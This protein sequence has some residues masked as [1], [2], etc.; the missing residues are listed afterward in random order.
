MKLGLRDDQRDGL[1]LVAALVAVMWIE[2]V[3]DKVGKLDLDR[4]GIEPRDADGLPGIV[5]SP[6]LHAGFD[7]LISNTV[8]FLMLGGLIALAGAVRVVAVT[9]IVGLIAGFGT[10]LIAPSG[11]VTIGASGI[12]FGYAS[13][14]VARAVISRRA[15]E[16]VVAVVVVG[17]W[18]TTLLAGIFVPGSGIS[19]QDH[20]FGAIGGV[21]AASMLS[22]GDRRQAA[23]ASGSSP[24][25]R[26]PSLM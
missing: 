25:E 20:L 9:V 4:H 3:V 12:V 16:L 18:G 17:V 14:L 8:P 7:H 10:W 19:W 23:S 15:M 22:R 6:F 11:S 2:E 26:I 21:V 24:R 5:A 1:A 13:Y